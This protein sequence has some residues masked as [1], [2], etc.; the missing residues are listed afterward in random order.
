MVLDEFVTRTEHID[1]TRADFGGRN[2]R[3]IDEILVFFE[4]QDVIRD[5]ASGTQ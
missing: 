2:K 5:S 4:L 3:E 1:E